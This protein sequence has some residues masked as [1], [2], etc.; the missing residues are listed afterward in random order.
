MCIVY[1]GFMFFLNKDFTWNKFN[2]P[3]IIIEIFGYL[4][5]NL[6]SL[7]QENCTN[8]INMQ[9]RKDKKMLRYVSALKSILLEAVI[10]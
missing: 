6:P 5:P 10:N 9:S 3:L 1:D 4:F 7:M 8:C 2:A